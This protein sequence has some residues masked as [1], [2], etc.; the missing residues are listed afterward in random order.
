MGY[1]ATFGILGGMAPCPPP[2]S[3]YATAVQCTDISH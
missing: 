1:G 2:K 3:T